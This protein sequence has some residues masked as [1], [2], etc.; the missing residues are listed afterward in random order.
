MRHLRPY[1][2]NFIRALAAAVK[3]FGRVIGC[4]PTGGGKTVCFLE[5]ADLAT[6]KG[7]TVLVITESKKI[8][9]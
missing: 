5:I 1:Q 7:K 3:N 4:L 2:I 6:A 8:F 9:T